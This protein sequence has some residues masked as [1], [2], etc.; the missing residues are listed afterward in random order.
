M[1][2]LKELQQ[3]HLLWGE[4]HQRNIRAK[5]DVLQRPDAFLTRAGFPLVAG[6]QAT[7]L[8]DG[9]PGGHLSSE[10]GPL[11]FGGDVF[12]T[13]T[14]ADEEE[15]IAMATARMEGAEGH[16]HSNTNVRVEDTEVRRL[17]P[18]DTGVKGAERRSAEVEE[19][20]VLTGSSDAS[21]R[22][23][24]SPAASSREHTGRQERRAPLQQKTEGV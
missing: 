2:G 7:A 18:A 20:Q 5:A 22:H 17:G 23:T 12:I 14:L 21:R 4:E 3:L 15:R 9:A 19:Q 24:R 1:T 6:V 8:L 11:Q 13:H 16:G 10:F